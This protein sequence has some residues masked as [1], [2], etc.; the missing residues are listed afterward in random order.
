MIPKYLKVYF[1]YPI[2][3]IYKFGVFDY[4]PFGIGELALIQE[5]HIDT[6]S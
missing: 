1:A 5:D 4:T 3:G 6:A 2:G